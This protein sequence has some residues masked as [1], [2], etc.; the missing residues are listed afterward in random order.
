MVVFTAL[1]PQQYLQP[2]F[3][4]QPLNFVQV[5]A[6]ANHWVVSAC[7]HTALIYVTSCS[8]ITESQSSGHG[9]GLVQASVSL[10]LQQC[11]RQ[12]RDAVRLG[13]PELSPQQQA[14]GAVSTLVSELLPT[15]LSCLVG[16]FLKIYPPK[17]EAKPKGIFDWNNLKDQSWPGAGLAI[18]YLMRK[19]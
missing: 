15:S 9:A 1:K 5:F 7:P 3:H 11:Q 4:K 13:T 14:E 12:Q 10:M 6:H 2:Q 18:W 16:P 19:W 8:I 17:G